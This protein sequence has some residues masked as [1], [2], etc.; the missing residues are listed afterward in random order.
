M[1]TSRYCLAAILIVLMLSMP[2]S[3]AG[4]D[5]N[6]VT[7]N[8]PTGNY[9]ISSI[10]N[11]QKISLDDYGYTSIPG[12][13][14]LPSRKFAIAIPPGAEYDGIEYELGEPV[15]LAGTYDIV[16]TPLNRV[17]GNENLTLYAKDKALYDSSYN[18]VYKSNSLHPAEPVEYVR[19]AAY[20]KYN[21]VDVMVTPFQYNPVSGEV[22]FYPDITVSIKLKPSTKNERVIIDHLENTE[23]IAEKLILNYNAAYSW[24][25]QFS[26]DS[27]DLFDMVIITTTSLEPYIDTL[28]S[29]EQ[30]KGRIVNVVTT[31]WITA[32]Y[33]GYDLAARM[34]NFL[35]DKYPS[36]EWGI[37][38][39]LIIGHYD[40]VPMRRVSIDLGYGEPETDFY[41]SELSSPDNLSW[42]AD[43]DHQYCEDYGDNV[44]FYAE[45]NVGRIPWSEPSIV[46]H[47]C[48]KSVAYELNE[49][50]SFKK[51]ILLLGAYFWD[52]PVTDNAV[53]METKINQDWMTD[54]T[55]TRLYEQGY[56]SYPMDYN[57]NNSN[58]VSV[59]SSGSYAFVNW[60]GHGSPTSSH[61][62]HGSGEAFISSANCASLNDDYPAIIFAD[63]CSNSDTDVLNIGQSMMQQGGV[64]FVGATKVAMGCPG[65]S[66]PYDGSSQSLDYFFTT[67]VTSGDYTVGQ[68]HA[69]AL[70]DMYTYNLWDYDSYEFCEWGA[71]WGN[72]DLSMGTVVQRPLTIDYPNGLPELVDPGVDVS[73]TVQIIERSENYVPGTGMMY[74]RLN[75]EDEFSPIALNHQ[76]DDMYL[77]SLPGSL[78]EST[79]QFYFSAQG[80]AG[81]T[82]IDPPNAPEWYFSADVG[83]LLLIAED[84]FNS[85]QGW[86][87]TGDAA[88]GHW[89]RAIPA[90]GGERGD[91]PTDYD[92]SGYCYLT[93]NVD[94]NS[95]V[96]GGSTYLESPAFDMSGGDAIVSFALW[97]TNNTGDNP[98]D[99]YF[100]VNISNNDGASWTFVDS[101]GPSSLNGW[102]MFSYEVDQYIH[103]SASVRLQFVASDLGAGSVVEAGI[104]AFSVSM[105]D[106]TEPGFAYM[107]GDANMHAGGW[108]P[109][110][111]GSDVTYL[112]GFFRGFSTSSPCYFD[113][114][115][116]SADAN[117]DCRVIGGD[118]TKLVNYFRG[119]GQLEYCES[120]LPLWLNPDDCPTEM[121]SYWP[122]C[123]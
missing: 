35:L 112:V 5:F 114:F 72:P 18:L 33:T 111:L 122:G 47:I 101:I 116:A 93:D 57:L 37:E 113:G 83:T 40:D 99:D 82:V 115:W 118:V 42:D 87:V 44:D 95:D 61:I 55:K 26:S 103:P 8:I 34:R 105:F 24:Y 20:R 4:E 84:D 98:G 73:I 22:Y 10:E 91:P 27:K 80:D 75:D 63:A 16:P 121:P 14:K 48:E 49:E 97:Y 39:V 25:P 76:Q 88:D 70:R 108:P 13:P 23:A 15:K 110:V 1:I 77:V 106:C 107:P 68:A 21:L 51:N 78:C 71:L 38:D 96:D 81:S 119:I 85:D 59:W 29:W 69:Q 7:V 41:Y 120:H 53:L 32:N 50:I 52:D 90:G 56:S 17:I 6:S 89:E 3:F 79:P 58:A 62:L 109:E 100:I 12:K 46:Q 30:T 28:V 19:S 65:W 74:Y 117:G 64:A 94:G 43:G 11:G 36:S 2:V 123:E 60:A 67:Y 9:D 45:I 86:S 54:W 31:S 104:D 66:G 92:G 102:Q